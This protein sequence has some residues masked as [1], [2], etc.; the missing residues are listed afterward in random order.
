MIT[1]VGKGQNE[2]CA[3]IERKGVGLT[4]SRMHARTHARTHAHR[5]TRR[6]S[7]PTTQSRVA[8]FTCRAKFT[9]PKRPLTG[10]SRTYVDKASKRNHRSHDSPCGCWFIFFSAKAIASVLYLEGPF[11]CMRR[12]AACTRGATSADK[13]HNIPT[14]LSTRMR[15]HMSSSRRASLRRTN[16]RRATRWSGRSTSYKVRCHRVRIC[17]SCTSVK[18][19]TVEKMILSSICRLVQPWS[20]K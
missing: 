12:I 18:G 6:F 1:T 17:R 4:H 16:W 3:T 8:R 13:P 7:R 14:A 20:W 10:R 15:S 19:R 2:I 11:Q 9:E 5:T